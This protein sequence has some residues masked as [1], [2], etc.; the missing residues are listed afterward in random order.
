MT[1]DS[2]SKRKQSREIILSSFLS[3]KHQ[4]PDFRST[5][6][7]EHQDLLPELDQELSK[8]ERIR[9]AIQGQITESQSDADQ[10]KETESGHL[11]AE[12]TVP[13]PV[14]LPAGSG[15][16]NDLASTTTVPNYQLLRCIGRGGFG[17]V[18]LAR[19]EIT[20]DYHAVKVLGP[21]SSLEVEG[22]RRYMEQMKTLKGLVAIKEVGKTTSGFYYVMPLADDVKGSTAVRAVDRYEPKTLA[23]CHQNLPPLNTAEVAALGIHLLKTLESLHETGLTHCDVKPANIISMDDQ[24]MLSDI[25]LMTRTDQF[26]THRGTA[27][28]LPPERRCDHSADLYALSKTLFLVATGATLD[29]FEELVQGSELLPASSP[30][31]D[32]L[33]DILLKACHPDPNCR[34][35]AARDMRHDLQALSET[36][37]PTVTPKRP[38][39]S[40]AASTRLPRGRR[41]LLVTV[42]IVMVAAGT[43]VA[44][45]LLNQSSTFVATPDKFRQHV[46]LA[47]RAKT[48]LVFRAW[49]DIVTAQTIEG[50]LWFSTSVKA[51]GIDKIECLSQ[52]SD[53]AILAV[54]GTN[55]ISFLDLRNGDRIGKITTDNTVSAACWKE[56]SGQIIFSHGADI[57][58]WDIVPDAEDF[59]TH[60]AGTISLPVP[61]TC[62]AWSEEMKLLVASTDHG[63]VFLIP[64]ATSDPANAQPVEMHVGQGMVRSLAWFPGKSLLAVGLQNRIRLMWIDPDP[65]NGFPVEHEVVVNTRVGQCLVWL[66]G[67]LLNVST[68][69]VERWTFT[70]KGNYFGP[71]YIDSKRPLPQHP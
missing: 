57:E 66:R 7:S 56:A 21:Q 43:L 55:G 20:Q 12:N 54:G 32:Q 34:Y 6:F 65:Q 42:A 19:N 17:E 52:T 22:V 25:G 13:R 70:N 59:K 5:L 67:N 2:S 24:W 40:D 8:L 60:K 11:F 58:F 9:G 33:R 45:I 46:L 48:T 47:H 37:S 61:A 64:L 14:K 18:W 53:P 68:E 44:A 31:A 1:S 50:E 35:T 39:L 27:G 41:F 15:D 69:L 38:R 3:G 63:Q 49:K 29:R 62:L 28:F 4:D 30:Q 16:W 71:P 10:D 26:P 51:A 23:W 36:Q